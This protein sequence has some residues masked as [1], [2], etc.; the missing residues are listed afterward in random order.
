MK[1]ITIKQPYASLIACG[2][3]RIE[4]RSWKTN[5]RGKLAI[6]AGMK[7]AKIPNELKNYIDDVFF[8]DHPIHIS[9]PGYFADGALQC[10]ELPLGQIIAIADLVDCAKVVDYHKALN[11]PIIERGWSDHGL[12]ENEFLFG[13]YELGRYAWILDNV[14]PI[15]PVEIKG[16]Q[17]LWNWE[18]GDIYCIKKDNVH[19]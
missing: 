10:D 16:K 15:E 8:Y 5:Y 12:T 11:H 13:N 2:A 4:T 9:F 6:H 1:A 7:P 17:G 18:D 3:K 14:K 19:D